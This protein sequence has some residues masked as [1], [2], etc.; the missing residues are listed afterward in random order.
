MGL[1]SLM[2]LLRVKSRMTPSNFPLPF[3]LSKLKEISE[4][5]INGIS[6]TNTTGFLE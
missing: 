2:S 6:S 3:S 5:R 1:Q 4:L